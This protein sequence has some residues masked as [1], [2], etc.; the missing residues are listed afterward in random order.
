MGVGGVDRDAAEGGGR[1]V[2]GL[3]EADAEDGGGAGCRGG[4]GEGR[5]GVLDVLPSDLLE[6]V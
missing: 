3:R 6:Q 1:G 2:D 5:G 4:G